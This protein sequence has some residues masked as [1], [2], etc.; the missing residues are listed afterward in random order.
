MKILNYGLIVEKPSV[1]DYVFGADSKVENDIILQPNGHGWGDYLP[2]KE[3]QSSDYVRTLACVTFSALNCLET[4][5]K[6]KLGLMLNKSDRYTAKMSGTNKEGNSFRNVGESV[7]KDGLVDEAVWPF[8]RS[9]EAKIDWDKYYAT[10]PENI[11]ALGRNF[12]KD[13]LI[14]YEWASD[15][16]ATPELLIESLKYSPLQIAVRAWTKTVNGVYQKSDLPTNHGVML[17]DYEPKK[18]W[19]I[20]D[21]YDEAIKKLAWDYKIMYPLKYDILKI[22]QIEPI[23]IDK[24]AMEL[25]KKFNNKIIFNADTGD[26]GLSVGDKLLVL[27]SK[28]RAGLMVLTA[29]VRDSGTG[30]K[31]DMWKKFPKSVF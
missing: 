7:R 23:I 14:Q 12:L 30:V 31:D 2:L 11:I 15:S 9:K 27:N 5:A 1:M 16:Q 3:Y 22:K 10:I 25:L 20:F 17:F 8:D 13:Y 28:D 18:Y 4:L 21:H 6:R 29:L 26:F 24:K 19:L